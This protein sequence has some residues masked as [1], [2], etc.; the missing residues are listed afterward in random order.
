MLNLTSNLFEPKTNGAETIRLIVDLLKIKITSSGTRTHLRNQDG[1][2]ASGNCQGGAL[3]NDA[4][5]GCG[6]A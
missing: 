6:T 1:N 2:T 5:A 3:T 4:N